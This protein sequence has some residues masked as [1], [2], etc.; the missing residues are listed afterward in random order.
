MATTEILQAL[1]SLTSAERLTVAEVALSLAH[2]DW[3]ALSADERRTQL[4]LAAVAAIADYT[5]SELTAFTDLDG[6]DFCEE[7]GGELE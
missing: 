7:S 5:D 6:E 3:Q 1:Q 4:E 2:T